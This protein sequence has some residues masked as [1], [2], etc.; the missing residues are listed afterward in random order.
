MGRGIG[1]F[2]AFAAA[3][4]ASRE[5]GAAERDRGAKWLVGVDG[6]GCA[7]ERTAFEREVT[8]ACEAVGGTCHVVESARDA[9]LRATLRCSRADERWVLELRTV[10][11]MLLSKTDLDGAPADR[12]RE[13]A[14]EVARDQAPERLL[15]A[16]SLR[17]TLSD[18]DHVTGGSGFKMPRTSLALGGTGAVGGIE[19]TSGGVHA[20]AGLFLGAGTHA[21]LGVTGLMGGS[22]RSSARHVRTGL[23][24]SWGAPF[25]GSIFGCAVEGGLDVGQTYQT[26]F[27]GV[28]STEAKTRAGAYGQGTLFL[29]VPL[30]G[31]RPYV[32][33]TLG[34]IASQRVWAVASADLGVAFPLF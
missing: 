16:D 3:F 9:E 33:T 14:M 20:L 21:T 22:G 2:V 31:L 7:A 19:G 26:A 4:L 10:E 6:P 27:T 13:A 8:L 24:L 28:T 17:D 11:G 30:R 12:I 25:D 18:G 34:V 23:G 32:A 1:A 5:A 29:Q 15:A